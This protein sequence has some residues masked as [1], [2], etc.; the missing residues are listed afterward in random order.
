MPSEAKQVYSPK[1]EGIVWRIQLAQQDR[2][3]SGNEKEPPKLRLVIGRKSIFQY[4][5]SKENLMKFKLAFLL[6]PA[7]I[8]LACNPN[9]RPRPAELPELNLSAE[10]K[11]EHKTD[12]SQF[13]A[14]AVTYG[15]SRDRFPVNIAESLLNQ[16]EN[17]VGKCPICDNVR[18]GINTYRRASDPIAVGSDATTRLKKADAT[19]LSHADKAQRDPA[20]QALIDRYVKQYYTALS[21]TKEERISMK[22]K[23][24]GG[25]KTGMERKGQGVKFCPS[26]DGACEKPAN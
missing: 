6:F 14:A 12:M 17:W 19:A 24:E 7:F 13:L 4:L 9:A 10:E 1:N 15:M 22:S 26:C 8:F 23:L 11:S 21:M 3:S 25:R 5:S 16:D 2:G 20:L 18:R